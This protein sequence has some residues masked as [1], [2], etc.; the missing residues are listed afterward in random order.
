MADQEL[1]QGQE[2][3][4]F[5]AGETQTIPPPDP[6]GVP[7]T[8]QAAQP[9]PVP[10]TVPQTPQPTPPPPP[11]KKGF[12]KIVIVIAAVLGLALLL[13]I[14]FRLVLPRFREPEATTLTWWSLR[15]DSTLAPLILE[16]EEVNPGV[17]INHVKQSPEDY[18]ERLTNS[19][20]R[21]EGPDIFSIHNT[22]VPMF[23]EELDTLPESVM[24]AADYSQVFYPV[25]SSDMGSGSGLVGIPLGYDAITLFINEDIF[26]ANGKT[27][28]STW[29]D[30]RRTA[31]ELT[32]R[33][34]AE[35]ITQAGIALGRTENVDFWPEILGLMMLQNGA[36][37][38]DPIGTL[39]EDVITFFTIFSKDD[40]VWDTTLPD[41]TIA[42]AAGKVA[43]FLGPTSQVPQIFQLNPS[44]R[45]KGVPLPQLPKANP[46]QP[47]VTYA[48]YW[49]EA[50]WERGKSK[51]LGWDFL[52]FMSSRDSLEK[53]FQNTLEVRGIGEPYPRVDM[54]DLLLADP[55]VGSV[56][57]QAP[58]AQSWYLASNTFDGPTGINSQ[59]T[60]LFEEL[61]NSV[62]SGTVLKKVLEE[63]APQVT[64]TL[65]QFGVV[66][67]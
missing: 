29:N 25:V 5:V 35:V 23:R 31:I 9:P 50:V 20:A 32:Q 3:Q 28:P 43:M 56:V 1:T 8:N 30:L 6:P 53:L 60:K 54:R 12:P 58:D 51:D 2:G 14:I 41:S 26:E 63:I 52:N 7:T 49:S 21:G 18:R 61:I 38:A 48:T 55:F 34:E 4:V 37:P 46:N 39:V 40:K 11:P 66:S 59:V 24:S 47:D 19:L 57:F 62:N 10:E 67:K 33:D 64:Q 45:F 16:Y 36:N 22:W 17:K 65:S 15:D 42:F 44:L 27:P 13:A